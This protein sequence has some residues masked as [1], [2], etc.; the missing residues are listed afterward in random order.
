MKVVMGKDLALAREPGKARLPEAFVTAYCGC[1]GLEPAPSQIH[2]Q[3]GGVI[4]TPQAS[5]GSLAAS[6]GKIRKQRHR[7][8]S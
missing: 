1:I 5:P 6:T 8:I 2:V 3:R 4:P 7:E